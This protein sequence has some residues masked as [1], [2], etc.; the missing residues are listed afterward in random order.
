[1]RDMAAFVVFNFKLT[2][3]KKLLIFPS[4]PAAAGGRQIK[5]QQLQPMPW[6]N[7]KNLHFVHL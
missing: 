7:G 3:A 4:N 1:V 5:L 6:G 2:F